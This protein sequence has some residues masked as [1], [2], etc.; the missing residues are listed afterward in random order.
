MFASGLTAYSKR[1]TASARAAFYK[2][3]RSSQNNIYKFS[4]LEPNITY[5]LNNKP[6]DPTIHCRWHT[7]NITLFNFESSKRCFN[8][9]RIWK[10]ILQLN[11]LQISKSKKQRSSRVTSSRTYCHQSASVNRRQRKLEAAPLLSHWSTRM[12]MVTKKISTWYSHR[13]IAWK[14]KSQWRNVCKNAYSIVEPTIIPEGR[15][16]S[17]SLEAMYCH[18]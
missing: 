13:T 11:A 3:Q 8:P 4:T 12:E 7:I 10:R 2:I 17:Y 1:L 5:N 15:W 16:C 9:P 14:P 6:L 18:R